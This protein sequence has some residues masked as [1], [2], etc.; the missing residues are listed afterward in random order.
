MQVAIYAR[1]SSDQQAKKELSISAQLRA[2]RGF[3]DEKGWR[4]VAEYVDEAKSGRTANRPSFIQMLTAVKRE[5]IEGILVWKLDRLARNMEISSS[6]DA[7]VRKHGVR[8]ISLHE[9]I[10][11]TPQGRLTARLFES[12]AEFY[13]NN[14]SQDIQRGL[15]E[16]AR[17]GYFPFSHAPIG[18]RKEEVGDGSATR[19]RLQP[20]PQYSP[21]IARIFRSYA[22]GKTVPMIV[23]ELNRE[24][25]LTN[26]DRRWT[27]KHLYQILRN[28]IYCGDITVGKHYVDAHGKVH[29]GADPV[30][31]GDVH[32]AL[33]SRDEFARVARILQRRSSNISRRKW[34]SSPYLLAGLAKCSVCGG[35]MSGTSAKRGAYHYYTCALYYT[36]GKASCPGVRVRQA[37]LEEFVV[38]QVRSK[39]LSPENLSDLV[40]MVNAELS[41]QSA[42]LGNRL[43]H[44]RGEL[45]GLNER[46]A[47]HY[48]ALETDAL[49]MKDVAP[50]IQELTRLISDA[51]VSEFG[52]LEQ[53]ELS[54]HASVSE[55]EVLQYARNLKDT[56]GR[57]SVA[58]ARRFLSSFI[59]KIWVD[60]DGVRIE[61]GIPGEQVG[62]YET[63]PSVLLSVPHSGAWGTRTS[64]SDEL[65]TL[66]WLIAERA[67]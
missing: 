16:V 65:Q 62:A 40:R 20:D 56:L 23:E 27:K 7:L 5:E 34:A 11:D 32:E 19:Y 67:F 45:K 53:Q 17:K 3:A 51:Q 2:L 8:I 38:A 44:I 61:Y 15:R 37:K 46:L 36:E 55:R 42:E 10:D 64:A 12:F 9:N 30:T 57:C 13:S 60:S 21:T 24:G 49:A 31:V 14:L 35:F 22:E 66:A 47:R 4:I 54:E 59:E 18:Y 25:T 58:D 6:V 26:L 50:R 39:I 28:P 43:H 29:P 48:D 63:L 33:I 52:L 41:G 1:V